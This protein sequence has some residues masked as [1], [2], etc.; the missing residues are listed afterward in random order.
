MCF[1]ALFNAFAMR[2][3]LSIAITEM[4]LPTTSAEIV[5]DDT[6][7]SSEVKLSNNGSNNSGN[8]KGAYDWSEYTQVH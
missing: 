8:F 5:F 2:G 6:C 7:P 3:C 1:L 4:A